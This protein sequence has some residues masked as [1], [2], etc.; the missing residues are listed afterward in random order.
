MTPRSHRVA[1]PKRLGDPSTIKYVFLLVNENRSYDQ[2]FGDVTRGNGDPSLAQ[3]GANTTPNKHALAQQFGLYDNTYDIGTNSADGHNWLMQADNPEYSESQAGEYTRSYDTEDDAL[4]HQRSGFLWTGV[5]A[6]GKSARNFGEFLQFETKPDGATWQ[7]YYCDAENMAKTGQGPTVPVDSSSPIPSLDAITVHNYPKF[8]TNI[9]DQ[10]RY[11][12]WKRD[13]AK[14][15]PANLNMFWLS[16]DHTGGAPNPI[17][18]VAD[19]DLAV[20]KIV[21]TISHSKYWKESAIFVIEDDTQNGVDHVDGSRGPVEIIS[22]WAQRGAVDSHYYTQIT[23]IRTIEQILGMAP[24]N[25]KDRAATPMATA[26]TNKPNFRAYTAQPNRIPLTYGAA[27]P[28]CGADTV[29]PQYRKYSPPEST[30]PPVPASQKHT[31]DL[32]KQWQKQQHMTGPNPIPDRANPEQMDH[33]TWYEAHGWTK[34]YP[35]EKKVLTPAQ[36]PGRY[37]PSPDFDG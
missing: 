3:F 26:F 4:G 13:F 31:A 8:D 15:G 6:A 9:P 27:T 30:P 2:V 17:A 22:P 7:D 18:Q 35:G 28:A 33:F 37:L 34:P 36:V 16:S 32:W 14:N 12:I 10:Y 20:G 1:I 24:M 25:Q 21:D 29:A 19:N 23:M 5:Q 11:E